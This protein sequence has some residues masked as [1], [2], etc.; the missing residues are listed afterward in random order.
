ML[1]RVVEDGMYQRCV[2]VGVSVFATFVMSGSSVTVEI[3][4]EFWIRG[5]LKALVFEAI[6]PTLFF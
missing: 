4:T 5:A 2:D 6:K 1:A 3:R